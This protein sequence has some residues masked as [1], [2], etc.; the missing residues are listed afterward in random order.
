MEQE[1][2]L[3]SAIAESGKEQPVVGNLEQL[4]AR[5]QYIRETQ[6]P[7]PEEDSMW[8]KT[9]AAFGSGGMSLGIY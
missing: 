5:E 1:E 4:A 3:W 7:E 6:D 9:E 2:N 8:D